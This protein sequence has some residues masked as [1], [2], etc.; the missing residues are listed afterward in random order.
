LGDEKNKIAI[1]VTS[2]SS[3]SKIK[4]T[5][6]SFIKKDLHKKYDRLIILNITK[7]ENH[8]EKFIGDQ[9]PYQIN[10]KDDIWDIGKII[11][12]V[13]NLKTD[14]IKNISNFLEDEI[15]LAPEPT[16]AKE[17]KT[18]MSLIEILSD[19]NQISSGRGFI[20]APDPE[21]KIYRRFADYSDFLTKEYQDLYT[22]YGQVLEDV[23]KQSDIGQT[24][25]RRLALYLRNNSDSILNVC[26]GDA[27]KALKLLI[28]K[29][30]IVLS[31]N[32]IDYD[33]SAIR[34]FLVEQLTRCNV[35]PNKE[36]S[37]E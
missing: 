34:F 19:E 35:F 16:L 20:E 21:G 29:Y 25:I 36:P 28:E 9:G 23:M 31:S 14:K 1:Q 26:N 5:L 3:L 15:K 2:T 4:K 33:E 18:F 13:Q 37:Y 6:D 12:D 32:G 24:R 27:K 10:T 11:E 8:K 7:K 17:I 30:E 22:E